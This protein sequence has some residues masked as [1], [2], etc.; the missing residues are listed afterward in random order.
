MV[1][2]HCAFDPDLSTVSRRLA[3]QHTMQPTDQLCE[4]DQLALCDA[5]VLRTAISNCSVTPNVESRLPRAVRCCERLNAPN[6]HDDAR[7]RREKWPACL[8]LLH[9]R[10][11]QCTGPTG[12]ITALHKP[13]LQ[14]GSPQEGVQPCIAFSALCIHYSDC[15]FLVDFESKF[16]CLVDTFA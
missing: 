7:R 3:R 16:E 6:D 13:S 15:P 4:T 12:Q 10:V 8:L 5:C 14:D 9:P 2:N 1:W 11:A